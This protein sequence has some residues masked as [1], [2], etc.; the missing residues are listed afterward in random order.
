[1]YLGN[2]RLQRII[3]TNT[4]DVDSSNIRFKLILLVRSADQD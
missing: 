4:E 2:I 3:I 1:M